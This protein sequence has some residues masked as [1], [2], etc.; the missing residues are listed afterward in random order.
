MPNTTRNRFQIPF[1]PQAV[2]AIRQA[3]ERGL[4]EAI[5]D[6]L[7]ADM[8]YSFHDDTTVEEL[9]KLRDQRAALNMILNRIREEL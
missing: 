6:V 7:T 4:W 8:F 3:D 1:S 5:E 2:E 9:V